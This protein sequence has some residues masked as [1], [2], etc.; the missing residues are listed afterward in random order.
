MRRYLVKINTRTARSFHNTESKPSKVYKNN[1]W[2]ICKVSHDKRKRV[3][4]HM[5]LFLQ[6][7]LTTRK[8]IEND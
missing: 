5:N 1:A 6:Q 7:N 8:E 3:K 2:G 4:E